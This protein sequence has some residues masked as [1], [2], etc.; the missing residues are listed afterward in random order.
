MPL[1]KGK[2]EE[3]SAPAPIVKYTH[4]ALLKWDLDHMTTL[5]TLGSSFSVILQHFLP[6][7]GVW[8]LSSAIV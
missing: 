4:Y 7:Y 5:G 1:M 6:H 8:K 2:L 3:H